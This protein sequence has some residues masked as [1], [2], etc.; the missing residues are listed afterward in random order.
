MSGFARNF[1]EKVKFVGKF[2][3]LIMFGLLVSVYISCNYYCKYTVEFEKP[4]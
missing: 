4:A 3:Y 1:N 2:E